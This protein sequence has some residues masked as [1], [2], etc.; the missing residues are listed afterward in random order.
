MGFTHKIL[1]N[2]KWLWYP[3]FVRAAIAQLVEQWTENPRV[4]GSS[5]C[6][7]IICF[8]RARKFS[9]RGFLCVAYVIASVCKITCAPIVCL[10][11][12]VQESNILRTES[13]ETKP[14]PGRGAVHSPD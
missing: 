12:S 7:G 11:Y 10:V 3:T 4:L 2:K 1:D 14:Q 8:T 13:L 5:P 6:G 9:A